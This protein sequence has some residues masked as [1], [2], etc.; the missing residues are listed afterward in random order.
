MA[1]LLFLS[2]RDVIELTT[3][4]IRIRGRSMDKELGRCLLFE[5]RTEKGWTQQKCA[6]ETGF[7]FR[8]ISQWETNERTLSL[9]NAFKLANSM[10]LDPRALYEHGFRILGR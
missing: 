1:L 8:Q 10:G 3:N 4:L 5:R 7:D 6:D 9:K 2:S